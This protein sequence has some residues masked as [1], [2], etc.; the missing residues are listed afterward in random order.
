LLG[1]EPLTVSR[2]SRDGVCCHVL[3]RSDRRAGVRLGPAAVG[4]RLCAT[5]I[6]GIRAPVLRRSF[7]SLVLGALGFIVVGCEDSGKLSAEHAKR[8]V[9]GLAQTIESDVEEVR[10]GVPEGAKLLGS[11]Y[12]GET[13][14]ADDRQAVRE[15]LSHARNKVQDLR[16]AKATFFTLVDAE[17]KVLR[18]DADQ[19]LMADQNAYAAFP[20]LKTVFGTGKYLETRGFMEEARGV[21]KPRPDGQWVA[22]APV[23]AKDQVQGIYAVGWAWSS[24]AYRLEF[25]LRGDIRSELLKEDD[26]R[27]NEAL[28]Y[29]YLL[30]GK[31]VIGA[32]VSPDVNMEVLKKME[33]PAKVQGS[34]VHAEALEIT[35]RSFGAAV[36]RVPA[37]GKD[38]FVAVLRSET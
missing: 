20:E 11:L 34:G 4:T 14:P 17:G 36:K 32:P 13:P 35:G 18:N 21:A 16:V 1:G 15:A 31:E 24:Y 26:A 37:L 10:R 33:L 7:F 8:H 28:V 25:K 5:T 23:R 2:A 38:V 27:K 3:R 6:H 12:E 19:D 29:V 30:V 22:A 9:E